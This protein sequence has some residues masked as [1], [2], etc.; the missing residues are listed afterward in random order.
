MKNIYDTLQKVFLTAFIVTCLSGCLLS[1][2]DH[3]GSVIYGHWVREPEKPELNEPWERL[4]FNQS[5]YYTRSVFDYFE[6]EWKSS[7]DSLKFEVTED[8]LL[9]QEAPGKPLIAHELVRLTG[10]QLEY[11]VLVSNE[12]ILLTWRRPRT[13][14]PGY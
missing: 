13:D 8:S 10:E 11:K 14:D 12:E 4:I 7:G 1:A 3:S 6:G 2:D 5:G 9:L